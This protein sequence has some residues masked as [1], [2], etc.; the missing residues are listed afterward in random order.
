M[1]ERD[2]DSVPAPDEAN[3]LV[4]RLGEPSR[5]D[6]R[7]LRLKG[8]RLRTGERIELR[9][10]VE[11][12]EPHPLLLGDLPDLVRL[13]NKVGR[14]FHRRHEIVRD[15]HADGRIVV[16]RSEVG[17]DGVGATLRSRVDDRPLGGMQCTL[18]ERRES[19]DL[20]DLVSE[21]LDAERLAPGRREHVDDPAAHRELP[22]LVDAL[23]PLVP[24]E[25]ERLGEP[26]H[27]RLV[28][29]SQLDRRRPRLRR[30]QA[31]REGGDGSAHEPARVEHVERAEALADEVRRRHETRVERDS[32]ARHVRDVRGAREPR[33]ALGRVARV[34]IVGEQ[35]EQCVAD[36]LVQ[37]R[38]QEREHRLGDAR[39]GRHG[40]GERLESLVAAQLVDEG[41]ERGRVGADGGL[42]H[43]F[44]GEVAPQG[45]RTG[46]PAAPPTAP[47]GTPVPCCHAIEERVTDGCRLRAESASASVP[48]RDATPD[49]PGHPRVASSVEAALRLLEPLRR[50]RLD[51][52]GGPGDD[53]GDVVLGRERRQ[54]VVGDGPR[55]AASGPADPDAE[56]QELL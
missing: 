14:A 1:R 51:G 25:R 48:A 27:P 35:D 18:R 36:L 4:L 22:S 11:P 40:G 20:L 50:E 3:E 55:V 44:G 29:D 41:R 39:P 45:H 12:G 19:T 30:R 49:A 28:S 37:R 16:V 23:D 33:G 24:G 7:A 43:A 47:R 34:R 38:E 9:R 13:P 46:L 53:L 52:V 6:G 5:R 31:L 56:P 21:E 2:D 8:V 42:V 54:H 26:V 10:A 32:A 15:R 17:L